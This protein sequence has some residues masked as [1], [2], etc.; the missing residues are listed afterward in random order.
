MVGR[1]EKNYIEEVEKDLENLRENLYKMKGWKIERVV[2]EKKLSAYG[3]TTYGIIKSH[4][5]FTIDDLIDKD[6]TRLNTIISNI[7]YTEYKLKKY[8]TY[9][10]ILDDLEIKTITERYLKATKKTVSYEKLGNKLNCS[11]TTAKRWHDSAISK[12]VD[13]KYKSIEIT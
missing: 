10:N 1:S 5:T 12:I 9:L 11:A 6:I 8:E 2:L 13:Y 3:Y 4:K 7:D